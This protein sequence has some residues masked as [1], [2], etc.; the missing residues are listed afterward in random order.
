[1]PNF[2]Y[3]TLALLIR[4]SWSFI[5]QNFHIYRCRPILQLHHHYSVIIHHTVTVYSMPNLLDEVV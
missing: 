2:H 3:N 1:M 5:S 4:F